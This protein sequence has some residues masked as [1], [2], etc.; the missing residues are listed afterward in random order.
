MRTWTTPPFP[1]HSLQSLVA[2]EPPPSHC[3][4]MRLEERHLSL[5]YG[6]GSGLHHSVSSV[7]PPNQSVLFSRRRSSLPLTIRLCAAFFA[8]SCFLN[9]SSFLRPRS[10]PAHKQGKI[11]MNVRIMYNTPAYVFTIPFHTFSSI[12]GSRRVAGG[13]PEVLKPSSIKQ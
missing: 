7:R 10:Y 9:L 6:Y 11:K 8:S 12:N 2:I 5:N 13:I 4:R 1:L 3:C